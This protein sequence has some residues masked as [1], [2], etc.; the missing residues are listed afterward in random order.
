MLPTVIEHAQKIQEAEQRL[1]GLKEKQSFVEYR[2]ALPEN[3]Q[4]TTQLKT[5]IDRKSRIA[6][7]QEFAPHV[8]ACSTEK[9]TTESKQQTEEQAQELSTIDLF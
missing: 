4:E 3:R 8:E 9:T 7:Q 2:L 1:A 6:S 5:S